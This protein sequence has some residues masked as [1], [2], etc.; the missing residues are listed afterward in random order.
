MKILIIG[1]GVLLA[2]TA[3]PALANGGGGRGGGGQDANAHGA[4]GSSFENLHRLLQ[5]MRLS[6]AF[7]D[8]RPEFFSAGKH[9]GWFRGRHWGWFKHHNPHWPHHPPMSP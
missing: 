6:G 5:V 1:A 9:G 4:T 2:V 3:S 7:W 8:D